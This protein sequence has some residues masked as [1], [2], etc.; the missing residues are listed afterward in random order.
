[1]IP[2]YSRPE[3]VA[4]WDPATKF[5]IWFEI[6]AH[7]GDAMADLGVIP[8]ENAEAVWKAEKVEFDVARIDEI[9]AET[10]HDVIAF[11]THL[12]EH[13]GSDAARFVHQ[14]MTSSDVLDTCFNIQLTRAAEEYSVS[15]GEE[16]AFI[17]TY[18]HNGQVINVNRGPRQSED[19][20]EAIGFGYCRAC[21]EWLVSENAF[22]NHVGG[23]DEEG[24]CPQ[25]ATV[26][27]VLRGIHLYTETQNDVITIDCPLPEGVQDTEGFYKTLRYTLEQAISVTMELDENE[28]DGFIGEVPGK[29]DRRRI[30]L[31]ETAEGGIGAVQS[32]TETPRLK[33]VLQSAREVLHEDEEGCEKA[34]YEC[35]LTFYNQRDHDLLD[36]SLVL[37]FLQGLE[38]LQI[39][40]G[41][42]PSP[43]GLLEKCQSELE[44]EVLRA[45]DQ[46][47][48][49]LPDEAQKTL[50]DGD[51]PIAEADFYYEPK[52]PVFV[53]GSPHH[54][55]Y[56]READRQQRIRL[57]RLNYR[58][59]VISGPE[60]LEALEAKI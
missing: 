7:A 44:K 40:S 59:T 11:L 30:V 18:E 3:M 54:K 19:E 49:P 23:K 39:G 27:E 35:L 60:D 57:K 58:T 38:D 6:E 13:V 55:D 22:D 52:I 42:A 5:R 24:K 33:A 43:E 2:R 36:R 32:L 50:Y 9:E 31:Y 8:R 51:E 21:N 10:R 28:L 1:M 12:A 29:P 26:D 56:V 45:I 15:D 4:I 25:N 16:E 46:A 20:G 14:G 47:D 17:L 34:C 53:D 37:P 41:A 48:L